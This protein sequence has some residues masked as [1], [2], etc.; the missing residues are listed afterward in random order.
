M[1]PETGQAPV[2]HPSAIV[3]RRAELAEDVIIGPHCIVEAGTSIGAGTVLEAGSQVLAGTTLGERNRVGPYALLGGEPM[4]LKYR[5][6]PSRLVVGD[7][8]RIREFSTLHRA[9][10]EGEVTRVGSGNFIMAYVHVTHNCTVGDGNVIAN[11][12]QIAGHA[13]IGNRANFGGSVAVHQY[14]RIGDRAMIG[15]HSKVTRDVP[16]FT[17]ADGHPARLYGLNVIGLRRAG[18]S[19]DERG[20][21]QEALRRYRNRLDW[22]ALELEAAA[23]PNLAFL[24]AFLAGPSRRGCAAFA[25]HGEP[26]A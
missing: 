3:D 6:E 26:L 25:G 13:V 11:N 14:C 5:G 4:D 8:N 24:L 18:F 2:V 22:R 10:G 12:A 21:L 15:M 7:D 16:P 9:T 1:R 20:M 19:A 17:L 23:F